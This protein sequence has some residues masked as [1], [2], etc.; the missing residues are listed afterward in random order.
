MLIKRTN[1][2]VESELPLTALPMAAN[3]ESESLLAPT[4]PVLPLPEDTNDLRWKRGVPR[5]EFLIV[6]EILERQGPFPA[7][8][9]LPLAIE[10]VEAFINCAAELTD[11]NEF[12]EE[13]ADDGIGAA[14]LLAGLPGPIVPLTDAFWVVAGC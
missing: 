14:P 4:P 10:V 8:W 3:S 7:C 12:D 5:M 13:A 1:S 11:A 6:F 2:D 9:P